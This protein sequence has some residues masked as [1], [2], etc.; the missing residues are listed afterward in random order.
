MEGIKLN[1]TL[2]LAIVLLSFLF[3][4]AFFGPFLPNLQAEDDIKDYIIHNDKSI[5]VAPFSPSQYY[6]LGTDQFGRDIFT[7]LILGGR[8]TLLLVFI[9]TFLRYVF[10][11]PLGIAAYKHKGF[12]HLFIRG[13]NSFFS[14]V[15]ILFFA[16][17]IMN[18]PIF[19]SSHYRFLLIVVVLALLET[20][21]VASSVQA[22]VGQIYRSTFMEGAVINGSS[23]FTIVRYYYWR[24]LRSQLA[25]LFFLDASKVMLLLGQLGFLSMF[26]SQTWVFH[27]G[28]GYFVRNDLHLWPTMLADTRKFLQNNIWIPLWPALMIAYTIFSLQLFGEGLQK[29][30]EKR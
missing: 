21:R 8:D 16:I 3:I 27:E 5:E 7:L 24:H 14:M 29:Q 20:G 1:K 15:P 10:A 12:F 26:F 2:K 11:V 13:L 4:F 18:L 19:I 9:I 6:W 17:L 23:F 25:I 28:I 22:H 30:L